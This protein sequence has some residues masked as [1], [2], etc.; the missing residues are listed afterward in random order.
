[1]T[2]AAENEG[3]SWLISSGWVVRCSEEPAIRRA[4]T[5]NAQHL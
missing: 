2:S 4:D 3:E 1:M 5:A